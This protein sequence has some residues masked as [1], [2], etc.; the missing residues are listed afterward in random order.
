MLGSLVLAL[1]APAQRRDAPSR[2]PW[3]PPRSAPPSS[4]S[5]VRLAGLFTFLQTM[6]V[7]LSAGPEFGAQLGRFLLEL[8]LGQAWLIDGD[9]RRRDH[10]ARA[11]RCAAW[12]ATLLT[13]ILAAASFIPL[14]TAGS[15]G[16]LS[17][18]NAAVNSLLLHTLGAAVWLG[19]LLLLVVLRGSALADVGHRTASC[20]FAR[21]SSLALAAFVVVAISGIARSI[22]AVGELGAACSPRTAGSSS[23]RR[24]AGRARRCWAPGTAPGSSRSSSRREPATRRRGSG[25]SGCSCC[26]SS[27]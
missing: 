23:P 10:G 9:R 7:K 2:S 13:A 3:T 20:V 1:F 24:R 22:V 25:R 19:G 21:Y 18:H 16:D 8:P 14:A 6:G 4:R 26:S 15:R 27:R 5:P 12:T 11:S 17:G